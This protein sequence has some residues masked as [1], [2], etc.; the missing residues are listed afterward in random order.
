M[1]ND[2]LGR[3]LADDR[4]RQYWLK[5]VGPPRYHR[6]YNR[7]TT[8]TFG[9]GSVETHFSETAFRVREIA[10]GDIFISY[11][12]GRRKLIYVAECYG[13][14]RRATEEQMQQQESRRDFPLF[15]LGKNL[16]PQY[17]ME[18]YQHDINPWVLGRRNFP[19][20]YRSALGRINAGHGIASISRQFAEF[21]MKQ[22]RDLR[23]S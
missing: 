10:E 7:P 3:L 1:D 22:I 17:G 8:R 13:G 6:D 19:V 2:T 18:W 15:W 9:E 21:L 4:D 14:L 20:E 23:C 16:T 11:W 5:A 12:T